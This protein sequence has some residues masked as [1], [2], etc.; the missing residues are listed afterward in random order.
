MHR[1]QYG[2]YAY[3]C[4][5]VFST[6][7]SFTHLCF[8]KA[9]SVKEEESSKA[10]KNRRPISL[11]SGKETMCTYWGC[12]ILFT[13]RVIGRFYFHGNHDFNFFFGYFFVFVLWVVIKDDKIFPC[14]CE[15]F[16]LYLNIT[17]EWRIKWI[18]CDWQTILFNWQILGYFKEPNL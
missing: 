9:T 17:C 12:P 14:P 4:Q 8:R 6:W 18:K 2:E 1:E 7:F 10:K 5:V 16:F 11:D 13:W 15:Q 3:W